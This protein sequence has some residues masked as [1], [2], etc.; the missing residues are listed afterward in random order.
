MAH[1]CWFR[2][3]WKRVEDVTYQDVVYRFLYLIC[4]SS[5]H[6]QS[7]VMQSFQPPWYQI[8]AAAWK[9]EGALDYCV[10]KTPDIFKWQWTTL[11]VMWLSLIKLWG[12]H[13]LCQ[14]PQ[15][16]PSTGFS[17]VQVTN[18]HMEHPII[19][20]TEASGMLITHCGET[21]TASFHWGLWEAPSSEVVQPNL[22]IEFLLCTIHIIMK[23]IMWRQQL[24]LQHWRS[25]THGDRR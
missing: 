2:L 25:H 8:K 24:Y 13:I 6:N 9:E 1:G 15:S 17:R 23:K 11:T 20:W 22:V 21:C 18:G 7:P 5:C 4:I 19:L 16:F 12:M 10:C 3:S 14:K